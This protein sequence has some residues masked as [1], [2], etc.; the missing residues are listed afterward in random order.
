MKQHKFHKQ[1]FSGKK[2]ENSTQYNM[3][4]IPNSFLYKGTKV[5]ST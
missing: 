2:A 4:R 3:Q 5:Q 1:N